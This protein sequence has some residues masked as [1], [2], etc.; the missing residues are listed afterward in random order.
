MNAAHVHIIVTHIPLIGLIVSFVLLGYHA[1]RP[2]PDIRR[3]ALLGFVVS[4]LFALA[5]DLS[6]EGAEEMVE[7]LSGVMEAAIDRHEDAAG[8]ALTSTMVTGVTALLLLVPALA[9]GRLARPLLVV[10]LIAG[11]VGLGAVGYTAN[12]GGK[13]RH[14]E[15]AGAQ[16]AGAAAVGLSSDNGGKR[17]DSHD[18]DDDD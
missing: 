11:V 13:I 4:G 10:L 9:A 12:L 15:I 14:T 17:G 5:A 7:R 8:F 16:T 1:W 6:G 18:D 3:L 2:N